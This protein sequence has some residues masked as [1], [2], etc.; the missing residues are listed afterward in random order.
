MRAASIIRRRYGT[1]RER[2]CGDGVEPGRAEGAHASRR[3]EAAVETMAWREA[4]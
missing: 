1:M 4:W 3:R 2:R